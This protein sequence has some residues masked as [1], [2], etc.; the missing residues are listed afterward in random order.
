MSGGDVSGESIR[1]STP[2]V[3]RR[4]A[5]RSCVVSSDSFYCE[6]TVGGPTSTSYFRL[7]HFQS[8]LKGLLRVQASVEPDSVVP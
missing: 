8:C 5:A 6:A 1:E 4:P 3:P 7:L 2:G